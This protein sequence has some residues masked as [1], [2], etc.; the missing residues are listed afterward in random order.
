MENFYNICNTTIRIS[1]PVFPDAALTHSAFFTTE[2]TP[3]ID[4]TVTPVDVLPGI[5][6]TLRSSSDKESVYENEDTIYRVQ[7][8]GTD[9]GSVTVY[10]KSDPFVSETFVIQKNIKTLL[11]ERYFWNTVSF[12]QIM[13]LKKILFFHASF[14]E[15][16]GQGIIFSAPSGTGKSTQASLWEKY[17]QATVING[18][19]AG[20]MADGDNIYVCGVPFCGTS[21]ICHNRILPLKAIVL[22]EQAE[23]DSAAEICGASAVTQLMQN[24]HLDFSDTKNKL[25]CIDLLI[26]I[27]A[28]VP[29]IRL[30]C[31]PEKSAVDVLDN[32]LKI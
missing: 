1:A 27:L 31:T 21:G 28:R 11:D 23:K 7:P 17:R 4:I 16:N 5:E 13:L 6:G 12:A 14:I 15:I 32:Y 30:S 18:D 20:V 25:G 22:P 9:P 2:K 10:K 29:V 8:M 3:D 19:K 26:D 24:I